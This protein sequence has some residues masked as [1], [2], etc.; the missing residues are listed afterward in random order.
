MV[1]LLESSDLTEYTPVWGLPFLPTRG[2]AGCI[3]KGL[4]EKDVMSLCCPALALVYGRPLSTFAS[5]PTW[6][7]SKDSPRHVGDVCELS[8]HSWWFYNCDRETPPL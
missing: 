4:F 7:H 1:T 8:A 3:L 6:V 5:A 2:G